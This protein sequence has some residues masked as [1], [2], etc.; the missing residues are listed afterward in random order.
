VT[1]SVNQALAR[2]YVDDGFEK[3]QKVVEEYIAE[4]KEKLRMTLLTV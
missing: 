2:D 4:E 1:Y 3:R